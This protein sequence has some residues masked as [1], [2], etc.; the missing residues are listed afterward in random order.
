MKKFL[1]SALAVA[2]AFCGN[3]SSAATITED[4]GNNSTTQI[5]DTDHWN[6]IFPTKYGTTA[7]THKS[8]A[9]GIEYT[10]VNGMYAQQSKQYFLQ[11]QNNSAAYISFSL[12]KDCESIQLTNGQG[13]AASP[14]MKISIGDGNAETFTFSS[15]NKFTYT[16]TNAIPA[17][18]TIKI[19]T[20][21]GAL[22]IAALTYSV[23]GE[24]PSSVEK[25]TFTPAA[26]TY[27]EPQSVTIACATEGAT[28][29]YS[30]DGETF[31]DYTGAITV[32]HSM[33]IT[34]KA[35]LGTD[36]ATAK[37]EYIIKEA[38]NATSITDAYT[39]MDVASL[40]SNA[41]T[42][43]F[44]VAFEPVVTYVNGGNVFIHDGEKYGLI[45]KYSSGLTAGDKIAA[46]WQSTI[47]N[48]NGLYEFIPAAD[49]AANGTAD[50]PAPVEITPA[51]L[52]ADNQSMTVVMNGV[53]FATAT[54]AETA[55]GSGRTYKG[56]VDGTEITLFN[57]FKNASVEAG[58]YNVTGIIGVYGTTPQLQPISFEKVEIVETKCATPTFSHQSGIVTKGT[59]VTITCS[60]E[61][62]K[63][64]LFV[65][66]EA[67]ECETNTYTV[68]INQDTDISAWAEKEGLESS[69]IAEASYLVNEQGGDDP[70]EGT[71][72]FK[73]P[74]C[75]ANV[76]GTEISNGANG[77]LIGESFSSTPISI[78]F[79]ANSPANNVGVF[80]SDKEV[81]WYAN[82]FI[83]V[84]P[85]QGYIIEEVYV[86]TV[87]NSKGNFGVTVDG[88]ETGTVSGTGSGASNPIT[89]TGS[90]NKALLLTP[91]AQVR[92][93]YISVK[94][95]TDTTGVDDINADDANAP[96]EYYNL[97]GIRVINPNAGVYIRR[98]G[99][100]V[101][102]VLV[103]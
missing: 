34:A 9:T 15:D 78:K 3:L 53:V 36:E 98:Q 86:N 51:Q 7:S 30:T 88:T 31:T 91:N 48:Y 25:P 55:T 22:R 68:T 77:D 83:T 8:V 50:I 62:S 18:T 80:N 85:N 59:E 101:T 13:G 32:D 75:A 56:T 57:N 60:T 74:A 40:A 38:V 49:L 26:G 66:E 5:N 11:L 65:D 84:T 92:F 89:W 29:T 93:N 99:N 35:T 76:E 58:T 20:N 87:S 17:N 96:V 44:T 33:T 2:T 27:Y 100:T 97:Q 46:N 16:P 23:S 14:K 95:K 6:P 43:E 19:A 41:E 21:G 28:L 71:A 10:I 37:A 45:F 12:P 72:I 103:K 42:D 73:A 52:T 102:K 94:Y 67:I 24:S 4:F 64:M 69:D 63:L 90:S 54:P 61:G 1:L 47:K 82:N 81:R 70:V 79:T 39:R